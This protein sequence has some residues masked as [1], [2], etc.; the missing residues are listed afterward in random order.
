M[1]E[2]L[3]KFFIRWQEKAFLL[4]LM[5]LASIGAYI[6]FGAEDPKGVEG[7]VSLLATLPIKTAYAVAALGLTWLARRRFRRRLSDT[8]QD[9]FWAGLMDGK[10]GHIV[11]FV[12]DTAVYLWLAY[13]LLGFFALPA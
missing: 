6:F 2:Y 9:Q 12:L 11:V 10:I 5:V 1:R 4:P 13:L 3:K 7:G 8:E